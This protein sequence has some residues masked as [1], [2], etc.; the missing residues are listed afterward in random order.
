MTSISRR[1]FLR[2]ALGGR[3]SP[4]RPAYALAEAAFVE[5]CDRCGDCV[6][7]CAERIIRLGDGGFP[8]IDFALG[9]CTLCGDCV[10]ACRGRALVGHRPFPLW[11]QIG[12]GCLAYQG[13]V[14][15]ACGEACDTGAIR[16]RLRVGG[17]AEP[18]IDP[19]ACTGC[20]GCVSRCPAQAV[21]LVPLERDALAQTA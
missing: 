10:S 6:R 21:S 9:G 16:F 1:R 14:C 4:V 7:A 3:R 17:A 2:G 18:R 19:P 8:E 5:R 11:V 12:G 15:R 20:G 13:V